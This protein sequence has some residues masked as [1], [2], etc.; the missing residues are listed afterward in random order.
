MLQKKHLILI[1][2]L[3]ILSFVFLGG[4]FFFD[5][6]EKQRNGTTKSSDIQEEMSKTPN[7]NKITSDVQKEI[8]E[9]YNKNINTNKHYFVYLRRENGNSDTSF[10]PEK[11]N[12]GFDKT[13]STNISVSFDDYGI[14][15]KD[16]KMILIY[17]NKISESNK[18]KIKQIVGEQNYDEALKEIQERIDE[19]K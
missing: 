4:Y 14:P 9:T 1:S 5:T 13:E 16:E 6:K 15:M 7:E 10:I 3:V 19:T 17:N 18:K 12:P 8:P 2:S 11:L